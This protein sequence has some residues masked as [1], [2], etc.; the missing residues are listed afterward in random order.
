VPR[1]AVSIAIAT[2]TLAAVAAAQ[3]PATFHAEARLVVLQVTVTNARG[4]LVPDLDRGAF[5]VFEDGRPQAISV[6][7]NDDAPVSLGLVIDNSGSMLLLRE[8]VEAAALA[9]VRASNP[10][11]EV[12]VVN[13]ADDARMDV[14]LTSDVRVLEAGIGRRDSFGG[15]AVRDAIRIAEGYL[16]ARATHQRRALLVISDGKDTASTA[17]GRE[18]RRLAERGGVAVQAL[19][20]RPD[21]GPAGRQGDGELG[22][23]AQLTGG[24]V[25][26]A[27]SPAGI[28]QM[29]LEMARRIRSEYTIG[30]TP[31]NQALD[32]S[33]RTVRVEI[34]HGRGLRAH[35]RPGYRA[36]AP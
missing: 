26:R 5:T 13:F 17:S 23:L 10:A 24:M 9:F 12:F 22:R 16:R 4:E 30:Y 18:I 8:A 36:T 1:K 14:P 27:S 28:D 25:R 15:S 33:F 7:R 35:T 6:F 3:A 11:D 21:Y 20:L 32:E 34:A 2:A 19:I 29:I 31:E